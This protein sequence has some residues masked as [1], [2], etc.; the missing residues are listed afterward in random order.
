VRGRL[1][2]RDKISCG[3]GSEDKWQACAHHY[4]GQQRAGA[5]PGHKLDVGFSS[6]LSVSRLL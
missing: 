5:M 4:G 6:S 2:V 1:Y 3:R